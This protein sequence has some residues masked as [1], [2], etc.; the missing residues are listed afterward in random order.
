MDAIALA[1]QMDPNNPD[2]AQLDAYAAQLAQK[3]PAA[4]QKEVSN[5]IFNPLNVN[6]QV[7]HPGST[8]AT[9]AQARY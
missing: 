5:P 8:P 6:D 7:N 4:I 3:L 9:P 1:K 2:N